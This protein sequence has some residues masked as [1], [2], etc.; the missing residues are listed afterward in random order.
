MSVPE[1]VVHSVPAKT[2]DDA[3]VDLRTCIEFERLNQREAPWLYP[4]PGRPSTQRVT[5]AW[6]KVSQVNQ[7]AGMKS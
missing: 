5:E 6:F 4:P 2:A 3:A 7:Y 1:L